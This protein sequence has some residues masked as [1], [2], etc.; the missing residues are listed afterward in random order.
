VFVKIAVLID[1][2]FL[3]KVI[4]KDPDPQRQA[5]R[6]TEFAKQCVEPDERLYRIFY[7]DCGPY[8]GTKADLSGNRVDFAAM[9]QYAYQKS[10]LAHLAR[11]PYVAVRLGMLSFDGWKVAS[12]AMVRLR[13]SKLTAAAL[14]SA[15]FQPD[16]KQKGVDMRIGL[17]T[18]LL[19]MNGLVERI[20]L[21]TCDS[22]FIPAMKL[23]RREGLQVVL[24]TLRGKAKPELAH[25]A[26][27]YRTPSPAVSA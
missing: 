19:A 6:I 21:V 17:D 14:T 4:K 27:L 24:V 7:Y 20:A 10:L 15:D 11:Q 26:D 5:L 18:A 12:T 9:P 22:D 25:H 8:D 1:G 3:N 23:A 16:F 13:K 2:A